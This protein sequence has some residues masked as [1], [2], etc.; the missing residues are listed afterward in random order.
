MET[1]PLETMGI[2]AA[3]KKQFQLVDCI[4]KHF[5]GAE[6][7]LDLFIFFEAS[8]V[9]FIISRIFS[10]ANSVSILPLIEVK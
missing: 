4:T 3:M 6:I 1:F 10:T 8:A 5:E 2:E 7:L 9:F